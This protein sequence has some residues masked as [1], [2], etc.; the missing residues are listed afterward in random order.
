MRTTTS[1]M[2]SP[3]FKS[4]RLWLNGKE[5]PLNHPRIQRCLKAIRE[6]AR[7]QGKFEDKCKLHICS[8]NN[9]PTAAGLA[10]S[11]AGYACLVYTLAK[12]YGVEGDVSD[13]AR[14]G[15]GSACRSLLGGFVQWSRGSNSNGSDSVASQLYQAD[16][17]PSLKV[18]ILVVSD[19]KKKV[20]STGGMQRSVETSELLKYRVKHCVP[21]NIEAISLALKVRDFDKFAEITMRDSN[22]FHA[23]AMDTY[24][25]AVYMSDVSHAI[26]NFVHEYNAACGTTKVAYTFDA[27]PN[28]VLYVQEDD[29]PLVA[30][31]I[32]HVF[33]PLPTTKQ[34]FISIPMKPAVLPE[35]LKTS[36]PPHEP[37]MLK[38]CMYTEIGSGPSQLTDPDC[39][40]LLPD[41]NPKKI[42]S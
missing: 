1:I 33:P 8:E 21:A 15:S 34:Q 23:V 10:S 17:W 16:H 27:G 6:R 40:L 30:A 2:K 26:V 32:Q 31:M 20:S 18:I 11:A 41:G 14:Q 12:L 38:Y 4:D 24:P 3:D 7:E 22:Q 13:I 28:A 19:H 36:F 37:G 35:D 42:A 39:H 9:F 29:V 5:E 25:P